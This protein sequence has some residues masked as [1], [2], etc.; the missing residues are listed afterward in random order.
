VSIDISVFRYT[1][2]SRT[3][4]TGSTLRLRY[5][6]TIQVII[7]LDSGTRRIIDNYLI[8]G[9]CYDSENCVEDSLPPLTKDEVYH[10]HSVNR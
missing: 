7:R 8:T 3:E 2:R 6:E 10:G 9:C 1:P 5:S 4:L